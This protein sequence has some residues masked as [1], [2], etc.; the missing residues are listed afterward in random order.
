MTQSELVSLTHLKAWDDPEKFQSDI[1]FLLVLPK[2][3]AVEERV[4]G[5]AMM[6]VHPYQARVST[7]DETVKQLTL[8]APAGSNWPYAL[9]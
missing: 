1:N 2:E 6:W 5:L 7:I 3:G 8:L 4:Y 9:V